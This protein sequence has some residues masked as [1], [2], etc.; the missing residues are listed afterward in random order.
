MW[1]LTTATR[2]II[3]IDPGL[4]VT[5]YGVLEWQAPNQPS[6]NL[7]GSTPLGNSAGRQSPP[8]ALGRA[9]RNQVRI[10]EAGVIRVAAGQNMEL[11]LQ[12]LKKSL[13]EILVECQ[14]TVMALEQ[15]YA[16]YERTQPAI[17]M[18][19]ARGVIMLAAAER[20]IP[21]T[22]YSATSVKKTISGHGRAPK[23]QMQAAVCHHLGLKQAPEPHDV[24]DALAI[25]LCH[26]FS[27][28][29]AEVFKD[30]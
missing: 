9:T 5:G 6:S 7:A 18:G 21:V 12:E 17:L 29:I 10:V 28:Q 26:L 13:D 14:P 23:E 2:R 22:S 25:A 24:A 16:H 19:H 1:D 30:T 27:Q 11:R 15:L 4:R 8:L 20:G 3:G